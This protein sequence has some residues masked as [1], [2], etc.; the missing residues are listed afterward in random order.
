VATQYA[1]ATVYHWKE[2]SRRMRIL[3]LTG[4]FGGLFSTI[5]AESW[6]FNHQ[7]TNSDMST[8]NTESNKEYGH[9]AF[10]SSKCRGLI[11]HRASPMRKTKQDNKHTIYN[12]W[13]SGIQKSNTKTTHKST[14]I[15][16]KE[17][18]I[19]IKCKTCLVL[20]K[21]LQVL[22]LISIWI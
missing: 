21:P 7:F 10:P 15:T 9:T 20:D 14:Q 4:N 13:V 11:K 5:I 3:T 18:K 19:W 16:W 2:W 22:Y 8:T 6:N 17:T 12:Q 1:E